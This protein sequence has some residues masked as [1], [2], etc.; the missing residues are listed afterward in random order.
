MVARAKNFL[1]HADQDPE[2]ILKFNPNWT[3]FLIFEAIVMQLELT[4]R[5]NDPSTF[6]LIWLSAKYPNVLLL[7]R[8]GEDFLKLKRIFPTL[9]SPS[10][11]KRTFRAAMNSRSSE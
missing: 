3:D 2:D 9:G 4:L 11:Q 8:F 5:F 1:K 10:D 7:D 6:F